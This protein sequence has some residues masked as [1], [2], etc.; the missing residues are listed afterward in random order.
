MN[1]YLFN[2]P[3]FLFQQSS[4]MLILVILLKF[5]FRSF[6][7]S[8]IVLKRLV[9]GNGLICLDCLIRLLK[10]LLC[11]LGF[12]YVLR[13]LTQEFEV[14]LT[15]LGFAPY[16]LVVKLIVVSGACF[17]GLVLLKL[18]GRWFLSF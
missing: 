1:I 16:L 2:F 15:C 18:I 8:F 13:L 14:F 11:I 10:T 3:C 7:L 12:R 5:L 17:R 4:F 6:S 9:L